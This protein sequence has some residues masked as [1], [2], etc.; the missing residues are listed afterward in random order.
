MGGPDLSPDEQKVYDQRKRVCE[1]NFKHLDP[2]VQF[3]CAV[4]KR[5]PEQNAQRK[6]EALEATEIDT[7][8]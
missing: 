3:S 6:K 5:R 7:C 1:Q 8:R 2:S 4:Q